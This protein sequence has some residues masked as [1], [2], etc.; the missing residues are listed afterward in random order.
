MRVRVLPLLPQLPRWARASPEN[1]FHCS[2][3]AEM[4]SGRSPKGIH[5]GL[6]RSDVA[7]TAGGCLSPGSGI[8][9]KP[10]PCACHYRPFFL[11]V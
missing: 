6:R 7:A 9:L 3:G 1:P 11:R 10:K 2:N 5:M 4:A 8:K